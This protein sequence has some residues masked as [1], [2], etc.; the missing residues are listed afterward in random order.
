[1]LCIPLNFTGIV[2]TGKGLGQQFIRLPWVQQEIQRLFCFK[3]YEGTLNLYLLNETRQKVWAFLNS[4]SGIRLYPPEGGLASDHE[5]LG[6]DAYRVKIQRSNGIIVVPLVTDY[7]QTEIEIVAAVNL[8]QT[9][10]LHDGTSLNVTLC[11]SNP[12]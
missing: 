10:N 12:G 6:A 1:V 5:C 7:P 2:K 11:D 3:P 9:Y 4:H 8:R